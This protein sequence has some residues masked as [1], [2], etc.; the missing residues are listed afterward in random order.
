MLPSRENGRHGDLEA[1]T[2]EMLA[3]GWL[4]QTTKNFLPLEEAPRSLRCRGSLPAAGGL[5][6]RER[7]WEEEEEAL[8]KPPSP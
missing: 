4:H 8:R 5:E 2:G 6:A 1:T 7:A 3:L